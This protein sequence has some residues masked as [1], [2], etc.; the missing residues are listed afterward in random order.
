METIFSS[1]PLKTFF[2]VGKDKFFSMY[3]AYTMSPN[4]Y[5]AK[6]QKRW[7]RRLEYGCT[8]FTVFWPFGRNSYRELPVDRAGRLETVRGT[9]FIRTKNE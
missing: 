5:M 7:I 1:A 8:V 3:V 4:I 9:K 6:G 2:L